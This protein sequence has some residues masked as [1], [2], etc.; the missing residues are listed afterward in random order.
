M[1]MDESKKQLIE[2]ARSGDGDAISQLYQ[3]YRQEIYRFIFYRVGSKHDAEDLFQDVMMAAF[4]GLE[5]FRGDAPFRNWCYEIARRKIAYMWREKYKMP[6]EEIEETLGLHTEIETEV[7]RIDA[8]SREEVKTEL[9]TKVLADLKENYRQVLTYRFLKNYSIKE[10][11]A[12][13][14]VTESNVKV[15]QHRALQKAADLHGDLL[16]AVT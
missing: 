7:D 14:G 5:T 2:R 15:L 13:M 3:Q 8:L 16:T 10:T 12:A 1:T 11:A 6:T 4:E 9:V